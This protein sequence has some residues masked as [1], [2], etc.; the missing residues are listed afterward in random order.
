[1]KSKTVR[2]N[3]VEECVNVE[4]DYSKNLTDLLDFILPLRSESICSE[5]EIL[6]LFVNFEQVLWTS[7]N[8]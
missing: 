5:M 8:Q 6:D 4:K 1:M 7:I 2:E 3:M